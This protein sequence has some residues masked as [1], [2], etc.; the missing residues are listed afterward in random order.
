MK[1]SV[2][3]KFDRHTA[4][5]SWERALD[6]KSF[7]E[8][9]DAVTAPLHGFSGKDEYYAKCSS[10]G[11]LKDIERPTLIINSRDD[12]FMLPEMLPDADRL[13]PQVTLEISSEGGH[14]GYISGGTPWNPDYY[15][16]TRIIEFLQSELDNPEAEVR[17]LPGM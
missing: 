12:P 10:V 9:D 4:A 2:T 1:L 8:F 11:F 6:A 14:V 7:A 3:R 5:F 13:S 15:L 16:S 17:A